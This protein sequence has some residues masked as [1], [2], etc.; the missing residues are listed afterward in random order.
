MEQCPNSNISFALEDFQKCQLQISCSHVGVNRCSIR[1]SVKWIIV[2]TV[3]G[4]NTMKVEILPSEKLS[5]RQ[6]YMQ[7]LGS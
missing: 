3:H 1:E 4:T 2:T 7:N 6:L 5:N